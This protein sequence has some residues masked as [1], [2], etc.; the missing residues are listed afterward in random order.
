MTREEQ[1]KEAARQR[2]NQYDHPVQWNDIYHGFI[3][4]AIYADEH[5]DPSVIRKAIEMERKHLIEKACEWLENTFHDRSHHSG[6]GD[7]GEIV[8]Y[9]FDSMQEFILKFKQ[10]MEEQ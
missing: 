3:S 5:P 1:I 6:R 8:T 9:D 7:A 4:G 2:A 10:R